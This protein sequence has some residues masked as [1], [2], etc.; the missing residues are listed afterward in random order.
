[1]GKGACN[2]LS[3]TTQIRLSCNDDKIGKNHIFQDS[4]RISPLLR[5]VAP[6]IVAAGV[7]NRRK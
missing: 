7:R 2:G 4:T 3:V 5:R 6:G 1:M